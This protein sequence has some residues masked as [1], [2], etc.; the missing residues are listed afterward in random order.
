LR[1]SKLPT[2]SCIPKITPSSNP[3]S[4]TIID[5]YKGKNTK[6]LC[7][8][9]IT[10]RSKT[11]TYKNSDLARIGELRARRRPDREFPQKEF[12]NRVVRFTCV[13]TESQGQTYTTMDDN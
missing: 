7:Y 12:R 5:K 3:R 2:A 10:S 11:I 6:W 8:L 13:K 1:W 4:V 9:R